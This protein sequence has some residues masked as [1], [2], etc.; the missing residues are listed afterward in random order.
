MKK[1]QTTP[2]A[3]GLLSIIPGLGLFRIGYRL[4][5]YLTFIVVLALFANFWLYPSIG[6]WMI[7]MILWG[8]QIIIPIAY[9]ALK[10]KPSISD[11]KP[12]T[13][14]TSYIPIKIN[15]PRKNLTENL[16]KELQEKLGTSEEIQTI[17]LGVAQAS[18]AYW[19]VGL[20]KNNLALA[21]LDAD[22]NLSAPK[23]I[24]NKRVEWVEMR[25]GMINSVLKVEQNNKEEFE[26]QIP[27]MF[28]KQAE[29][30]C[31]AYPGNV[32]Y[33][34]YSLVGLYLGIPAVRESFDFYLKLGIYSAVALVIFFGDALVFR[35][36]SSPSPENQLSFG[37]VLAFGYSILGWPFLFQA[38]DEQKKA[39]TFTNRGNFYIYLLV[40]VGIWLFAIY[41][42]GI[43]ILGYHK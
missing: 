16:K 3:I 29:L 27:R 13:Y 37:L 43:T 39:V 31:K 17:I 40:A 2:L 33:E 22:N 30:I 8:G 6:L 35:K 14:K 21:Q 5:S 1:I 34:D 12:N 42:S 26:L 20:L 32:S 7:T 38:L 23:I 19:C 11:E 15:L 10:T 36:F 25:I 4:L 24:L 41:V 28:Q 9:L 18:G